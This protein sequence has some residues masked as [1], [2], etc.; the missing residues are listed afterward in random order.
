MAKEVLEFEVKDV[1]KFESVYKE[2]IRQK[3]GIIFKIAQEKNENFSDL[4]DEF[5]PEARDFSEVWQNEYIFE[6]KKLNTN[7]VF[8]EDTAKK[9]TLKKKKI[10]IKKNNNSIEETD[11]NENDLQIINFNNIKSK[12]K[13]VT[14]NNNKMEIKSTE[15]KVDTID[16][17]HSIENSEILKNDTV[18]NF[19]K[20][21]KTE[22][23]TVKKKMPK[24]LKRK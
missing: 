9:L 5:V 17:N 1:T 14:E 8:T 18:E 7:S 12:P 16:N 15:V 11:K 23:K 6:N 20:I 13:E 2:L 24:T 21:E 19:S 3:V 10:V 4:L 22:L